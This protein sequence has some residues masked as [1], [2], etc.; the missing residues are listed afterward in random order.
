VAQQ[1]ETAQFLPVDVRRQLSEELVCY[2][3][4]VAYQEWPRMEADIL[5]EA[6]NPWGVALFRTL[7]TADPTTAAEQ[8]AYGKWL[9]QTSDR[10]AA[11]SE[12]IHGAVGVIPGPLW[13]VLFLTASVILVFM[14]F[15]ADSGERAIVQAVL[16][17]S[18]V[19]VIT[20]TLLVIG[21]LNDPFQPG[22]GSL[23]PVAME[24]TLEILEQ[25]RRVVREGAQ[26]PCDPKGVATG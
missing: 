9:D 7:Q 20:A 21:F 26:L 8:A 16:I 6:I 13:V 19:A 11:R 4:S 25:E 12:R 24:R 5:G 1:F 17:G 14:L 15:F 18:V 22:L 3:R 23:R 2:A 10:E